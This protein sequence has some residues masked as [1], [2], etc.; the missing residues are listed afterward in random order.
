VINISKDRVDIVDTSPNAPMAIMP[1]RSP[2]GRGSKELLAYTGSGAIPIVVD[3]R[4][5]RLAGFGRSGIM[6]AEDEPSRNGLSTIE[7]R[8]VP[9]LHVEVVWECTIYN[10]GAWYEPAQTN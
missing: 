4:V 5:R 9:V 3:L 8:T 1:W 10:D 6:E 2:S 7:V